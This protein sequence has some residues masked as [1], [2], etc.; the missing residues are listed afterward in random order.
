M[1]RAQHAGRS[2]AGTRALLRRARCPARMA[3][4]SW[5]LTWTRSRTSTNANRAWTASFD[6]G[7]AVVARRAST[8]CRYP[9]NWRRSSKRIGRVTA[10]RSTTP[11]SPIWPVLR[12]VSASSSP[13]NGRDRSTPS[14]VLRTAN[15]RENDHHYWDYAGHPILNPIP[16]CSSNGLP[17]AKFQ[18]MSSSP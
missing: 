10:Y 1:P 13:T 9:A 4:F 3:S 18:L 7:E 12:A 15:R 2:A 14:Q 8:V 11:R 16:G 17:P 5:R 6:K